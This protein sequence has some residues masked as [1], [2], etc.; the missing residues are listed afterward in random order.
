M[1]FVQAKRRTQNTLG[2]YPL[3]RACENANKLTSFRI[4]GLGDLETELPNRSPYLWK[5]MV[6]MK[7]KT[8]W[9]I[10]R[11]DERECHLFTVNLFRKPI[12]TWMGDVWK[13]INYT[14]HG[15]GTTMWKLWRV[16]LH[17]IFCRSLV[18]WIII[19]MINCNLLFRIACHVTFG[20]W[21]LWQFPTFCSSTGLL[22]PPS[23]PAGSWYHVLR[24]WLRIY[25][26]HILLIGCLIREICTFF[27]IRK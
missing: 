18:S 1:R 13:K 8:C 2:K 9:E 11:K 23:L 5:C 14:N 25:R 15:I 17:V 12:M 4:G 19:G 24:F 21:L 22:R 27:R 7:K 10:L 26:F 20:S 16:R 6:Q 3:T